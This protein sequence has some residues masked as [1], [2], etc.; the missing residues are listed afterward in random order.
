MKYSILVRR[1][2]PYMIRNCLNITNSYYH[3]AEKADIEKRRAARK[4][5]VENKING[6]IEE[7]NELISRSR[8]KFGLL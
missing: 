6:K 8:E 3:Q 7:I 1:L 4:E 2:M 5:N